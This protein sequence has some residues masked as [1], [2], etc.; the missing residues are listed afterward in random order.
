MGPTNCHFFRLLCISVYF[1]F[2][3][4]EIHSRIIG[5][6]LAK[7]EQMNDHPQIL[8]SRCNHC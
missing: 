6:Y 5:K 2:K 3:D 1:F 8:P 4:Y 7:N